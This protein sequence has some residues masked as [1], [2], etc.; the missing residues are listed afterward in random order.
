MRSKRTMHKLASHIRPNIWV[1][2]NPEN[3]RVA[4]A[5]VAGSWADLEVDK[6]IESI[7]RAREEGSRPADRP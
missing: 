3:V 7:H 4:L 6:L 5:K 2:Y 1:G